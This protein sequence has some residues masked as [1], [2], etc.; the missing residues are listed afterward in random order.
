MDDL[1]IVELYWA[2]SESA[3]E[4]SQKKYGRYC[5]SIARNILHDEGDSE[6]CVNDTYLRAWSAMPPHRPSRLG[7]FLG[8]IT[9]NLSLNRLETRLA[10][11]RGFDR[12]ALILD[13]LAECIPDGESLSVADEMVL[14]DVLNRFLGSLP[15]ETAILF[16][17]RY[18]YFRSVKDL[19][20]ELGMSESKVK[21][22]LHR[23]RNKC[24]L[25]FEKEGITL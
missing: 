20:A 14:K 16:L 24:K 2:R 9:R 10:E 15:E 6:E 8:K 3:I 25:F 22:T 5:H 11:K 21:V 13:E 17:G 18:W 4:E 12:G 7:A 23:T 19:A 1:Q